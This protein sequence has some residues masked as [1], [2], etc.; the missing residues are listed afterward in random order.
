V[1]PSAGRVLAIDHGDRRTGLAISDPLGFSAQPLV[2]LKERDEAQLVSQVAAL[3]AEYDVALLLVGLPLNMNGTEG[4][5]AVRARAF[6]EKL[7]AA[8]E[9][10]VEYLDE[11]LTSRQAERVLAGRS[12][13]DRKRVGDVVAAQILLQTWLHL[14]GS[15]SQDP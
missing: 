10:P 11:R 15:R 7:A 4:P 13:A 9:R 6:G 3:A 2:M 5:R 1:T 14:Q 12:R 8:A